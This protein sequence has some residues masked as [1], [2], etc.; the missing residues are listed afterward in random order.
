MTCP[1]CQTLN[2]PAQLLCSC[3]RQ[4]LRHAKLR[5][6][7]HSGKEQHLDLNY[8]D[9]T[10]GREARND[11][12]FGDESASRAHAR[13]RLV[14][15]AYLAEDLGSKNGTYVNGEKIAS[16]Q[17]A[18]LDCL[19]IGATRIYFVLND[20]TYL[21][22]AARAASSSTGKTISRLST[23]SAELQGMK[24]ESLLEQVLP[25]LLQ[26][27][28]HWAQ[29]HRATLWLP[30]SSGD[31]IPRLSLEENEAPPNAPRRS[32]AWA[33][34]QQLALRVFRSGGTMVREQQETTEMF[35]EGLVT[36]S[37]L[38]YQL[39]GIPLRFTLEEQRGSETFAPLGALL[40]ERRAPG[41]KLSPAKLER[42][43]SFLA[44]AERYVSHVQ[45]VAAVLR[46]LETS[47][48][49]ETTN[50]AIA[51]QQHL[52]PV[53]IP[54]VLGYDLAGWHHPAE[55]VSGDYLDLVPLD[56][57]EV[58]LVLGD[59]AGKGLA[60]ATTIFALQSS[61]H[62]LTTYESRLEKIM[63]A[64]N[65]VAHAVGRASI[66]TTLF[67]GVLNPQRRTLHYINAGHT[68][69]LFI[70]SS[71][72]TPT[73]ELLRSNAAALGVLEAFNAEPKQLFLP[74]ASALLLFTDGL[75]EAM[76]ENGEQYGLARLTERAVAAM[77]SSRKASAAHVLEALRAELTLYSADFHGKV[78]RHDDQA[79]LVVRVR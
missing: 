9:Y 2:S 7:E 4:T 30:D 39:L 12:A 53:T 49:N 37:E 62:L 57:G 29:A 76:N 68:P 14:E 43:K 26:G 70:H 44:Q 51:I 17:L 33:A 40:L 10:I 6:V 38:A 18:S 75:T 79:A 42:L 71:E 19:Q 35:G 16:R 11:L 61:L 73:V 34:E 46:Q 66:F 48:A 60:A 8:Q 56:M 25:Q 24:A 45:A 13:L 27:A 77:M 59:V 64:L 5:V 23:P 28:R 1:K 74:P 72:A 78:V 47:A 36:D 50:A 55:A 52:R 32:E 22:G 63:A 41:Q 31:L 15:G 20:V 3:C 54:Q 67:L 58:L 65:R 69:G 21:S